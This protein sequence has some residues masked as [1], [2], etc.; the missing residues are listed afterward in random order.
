MP[1][2]SN[3]L[4]FM[5]KKVSKTDSINWKIYTIKQGNKYEREQNSF[6]NKLLK[7]FLMWVTWD[8]EMLVNLC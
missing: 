1:D 2:K 6:S 8:L 4:S 5:K 7:R 3:S